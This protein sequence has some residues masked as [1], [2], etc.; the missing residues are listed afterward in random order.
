MAKFNP[1][2]FADKPAL[3]AVQTVNV[4]I[5]INPERLNEL[6]TKLDSTRS[7]FS[8]KA[9]PDKSEAKIHSSTRESVSAT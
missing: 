1:D 3:P 4:G 8:P 7:T 9:L 2:T 6:R 5:A